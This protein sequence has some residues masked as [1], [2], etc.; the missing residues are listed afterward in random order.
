MVDMPKKKTKK[1]QTKIDIIEITLFTLLTFVVIAQVIIPWVYG[2]KTWH[3]GDSLT[4]QQLDILE[5]NAAE[6]YK[7]IC[8]YNNVVIFH[9]ELQGWVRSIAIFL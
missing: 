4:L 1:K 9:W 3:G 7:N 5:K 6:E 8:L 2:M